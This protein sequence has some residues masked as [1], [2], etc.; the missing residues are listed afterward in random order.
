MIRITI[1]LFAAFS[2]VKIINYDK[3]IFNQLEYSDQYLDSLIWI[4]IKV[5]DI[6]IYRKDEQLVHEYQME[7]T[8]RRI[9]NNFSINDTN[10]IDDGTSYLLYNEDVSINLKKYSGE[11]FTNDIVFFSKKWGI[12]FN[13]KFHTGLCTF[14][15]FSKS[16]TELARLKRL[17]SRSYFFIFLES[18]G[19]IY[20]CNFEHNTLQGI[21]IAW[22]SF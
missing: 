4:P 2:I 11:Y 14:E 19:T 17:R 10:S 1:I 8:S 13:D 9:F 5:N 15:S 7:D 6:A 20:R 21:W 22:P 3:Y 12:K 16:S 18:N